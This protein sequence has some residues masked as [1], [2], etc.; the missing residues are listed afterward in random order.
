[1]KVALGADHAGYEL[2]E[3]VKKYLLSKGVETVDLGT[4]STESVD[5]PDYAVKVAEQVSQKKVD[6]GVLV[7]KSGIGMS[8][9]AN[10]VKGVRAAVVRTVEDTKLARGHNDA[11]LLALSGTFTSEEEAKKIVDAWMKTEFEGGR[12]ERRVGKIIELEK[13]HKL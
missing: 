12:H 2:K 10:K 5:Y 6:W 7:C 11:N 1:V 9:V 3:K 8:I 4:G 13:K